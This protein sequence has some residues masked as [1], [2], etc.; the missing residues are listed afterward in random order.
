MER[1]INIIQRTMRK[2]NGNNDNS[3]LTLVENADKK[4]SG[5]RNRLRDYVMVEHLFL[6]IL[7]NAFF[8]HKDVG[9][10]NGAD[11]ERVKHFAEQEAFYYEAAKSLRKEL[12]SET[13]SM[14][15]NY[16]AIVRRRAENQ[17]FTEVPEIVA[18]DFKGGIESASAMEKFQEMAGLLN[19]Q[20]NA[21]DE[22]RERTIELLLTPLIDQESGEAK[23]DELETMAWLQEEG[24]WLQFKYR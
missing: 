4:L 1:A 12:M 11:V 20:A 18:P 10:K 24:N 17:G 23:G 21:M 6:F 7:G 14:A 8:N 2:N 22:W 19:D 3:D 5:I 15:L 16:F 13:E 9:E